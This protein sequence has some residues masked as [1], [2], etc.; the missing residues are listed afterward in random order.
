[1]MESTNRI[2]IVEDNEAT[3]F[4]YRRMLSGENI[5]VDTT[6]SVDEALSLLENNDYFVVI[7]D[8]QVNTYG[9]ME[10]YEVIK[11]VKTNQL[12]CRIVVITASGGKDAHEKVMALGADVYF[13][14]PVSPYI[15]KEKI[16]SFMS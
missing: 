3:L 14:K 1:M 12:G 6:Q 7:T 16:Q 2:L 4:A 13:E 11:K 9:N 8:L 10:G 15:L 5:T